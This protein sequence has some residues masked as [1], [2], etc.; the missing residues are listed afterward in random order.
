MRGRREQ[1]EREREQTN[2]MDGL[3]SKANN[4]G[5]IITGQSRASV[6]VLSSSSVCPYTLAVV[7]QCFLI[8]SQSDCS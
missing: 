4:N 7:V 8:P 1:T 6:C 5:T 2:R 3:C